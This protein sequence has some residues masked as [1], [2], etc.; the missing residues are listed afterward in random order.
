MI[1]KDEKRL[2]LRVKTPLYLPFYNFWHKNVYWQTEAFNFNPFTIRAQSTSGSPV[3]LSHNSFVGFLKDSSGRFI[4]DGKD[5]LTIESGLNQEIYIEENCDPWEAWQRY[6]KLILE[7]DNKSNNTY[8]WK[9]IEYCT[10]VEQK[11][12]ALLKY[13]NPNLVLEGA[14]QVLDQDFIYKYLERLEKLGLPKGKFTIDSGW[15]IR[16]NTQKELT[17][18]DWKIDKRKFPDLGK[19]IKEIEKAGY[20]PGLWFAPGFITENS[21]LGNQHPDWIGELFTGTSEVPQKGNNHFLK[22]IPEL[23]EHYI[24]LF[25]T[26]INMGI[27][28][29]KLDMYYNNKVLMKEILR[30]NYEAIKLLDESIEVEIHIPDIFVSKYGDTIRINDVLINAD[31]KWRELTTE[32]YRVCRYSAP[33]KIINLDHVGGNNH[34]VKEKEYLEHWNMLKGYD[35]YPVISLLPDYYSKDVI[36]QFVYEVK[37]KNSNNNYP[38]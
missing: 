35:G 32:H 27:K 30:I 8:F 28:K 9:D 17:F 13:S 24:K 21:I 22:P 5:K 25:K 14:R 11:R 26:F 3:V 33:H 16:T 20:I 7:D 6:N 4:F 18:G 1:V 19:I 38:I 12:Q 34:E 31:G 2:N 15:N 37:K 29:F 23:K 10:W 36:E